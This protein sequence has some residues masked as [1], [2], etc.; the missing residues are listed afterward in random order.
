MILKPWHRMMATSLLASSLLIS[1]VTAAWSHP[2]GFSDYSLE[3]AKQQAQKDNKFLLVDFMAT[4]C[5]PCR[6]MEATT[7]TDSTVQ[8]WI[9]ENAIAVQVDVD[10][11]R[12][13][14]SAFHI[15]AM[16][17]VVL[18][19][20]GG[21]KEFGRQ[22]G[23]MDAGELLQWLKGAKGDATK[24][25]DTGADQ[26]SSQ[27]PAQ[28]PAQ[29]GDTTDQPQ[30]PP[31]SSGGGNTLWDHLRNARETQAAGKNED[32]LNEYIWL[33]TNMSNDDPQLPNGRLTM[34]PYEMKKLAAVY[35][36]AKTN[37]SEIRDAAEQA[38]NRG[39]WIAL[40]S[41]L[42]DD[43]RTLAWFDKAK[44]D[45]KH[46]H[47]IINHA[48]LLEPVLFAQKRWSDAAKYLYPD[49]MAKL[50]EYYKHAQEMKK[51]RPDTEFAK[52]FDPFPPMVLTLYAAYLGAGQ[53]AEAQKI[54]DECLRLDNTPEMR[55]G[56]ENVAKGMRQARGT[57]TTT[58]TS[59]PGKTA[60]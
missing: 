30:A 4:W 38:N 28:P 41:I 46:Q 36:P 59:Q 49:P 52:D 53:D 3:Q 55:T 8:A 21:G 13:A 17:T 22:V 54:M 24:S 27:P 51:P 56:L 18:L 19:T 29:S 35:P 6:Q 33:W 60:N 10:K 1:C 44:L 15:E 48:A 43:A 14:S 34:L 23:Y 16:P 50:Q 32:A 47:S 45:P 11:D 42:N 7:W 25:A 31:K 37:F 2:Q 5:P 26:P 12:K 40:N 57:T 9:K 58:T 39:D 20:Q